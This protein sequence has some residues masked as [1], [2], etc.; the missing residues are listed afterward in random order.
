M[1]DQ[2]HV[3]NVVFHKGSLLLSGTE[4]RHV[5]AIHDG[6]ADV[7][8]RVPTGTHNAQPF[9]R[10]IVANHTARN[11]IVYLTRGG[12]PRRSFPIKTYE[13]AALINSSLPADHARQAFGRGLCMWMQRLLIAGSSPATISVFDFDTRERL[14]CI[15]L[16]MDLRNAIHGLELWPF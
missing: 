14:V 9:L 2:L 8:A 16:T 1:R 5:V 15:N 10:G 13:R 6:R 3:N 11:R 12:W 7:F 4:M